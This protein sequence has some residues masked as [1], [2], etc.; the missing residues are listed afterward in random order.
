[1]AQTKQIEAL[2]NINIYFQS[3]CPRLIFTFWLTIIGLTFLV[4]NSFGWFLFPFYKWM[5]ES[6]CYVFTCFII[7]L[8]IRKCSRIFSSILLRYGMLLNEFIIRKSSSNLKYLLLFRLTLY[9]NDVCF[10]W[11]SKLICAALNFTSNTETCFYN[12]VFHFTTT[13]DKKAILKITDVSISSNL[14]D[15]KTAI[16]ALIVVIWIKF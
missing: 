1:M 16:T 15:N 7:L 13:K 9:P 6:L 10:L 5:R 12:N 8:S 11:F 14:E 4:I 2:I 3:R